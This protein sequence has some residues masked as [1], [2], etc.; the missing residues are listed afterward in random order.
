MDIEN[1]IEKYTYMHEVSIDMHKN[2]FFPFYFAERGK[3]KGDK[4]YCHEH[5]R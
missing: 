3:G 5:I 1:M 4:D 2:T